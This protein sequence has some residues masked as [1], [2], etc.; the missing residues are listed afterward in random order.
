MGMRYLR[1]KRRRNG[2]SAFIY[3]GECS[4]SHL[5]TTDGH[6]PP[7][8]CVTDPYSL[9]RRRYCRNLY[10]GLRPLH[11]PSRRWHC[12]LPRFPSTR[13][14]EIP[15]QPPH[16]PDTINVLLSL[17]ASGSPVNGT[18]YSRARAGRGAMGRNRRNGWFATNIEGDCQSPRP[19]EAW[20]EEEPWALDIRK[21][22]QAMGP[23]YVQMSCRYKVRM[24]I[25]ADGLNFLC[26]RPPR[27]P[28]SSPTPLVPQSTQLRFS[29]ID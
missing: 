20:L 1:A 21:D 4:S 19:D 2:P 14:I 24:M 18:E 15:F 3:S 12:D 22:S 27:P 29:T 28:P 26:N 5:T 23:E 7:Y 10:R 17:F 13:I 25:E 8:N 6:H 9:G 11:F 16:Y